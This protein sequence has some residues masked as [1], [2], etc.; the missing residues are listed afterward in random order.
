[1]SQ[2]DLTKPCI[3]ES[4]KLQDLIP[5]VAKQQEWLFLHIIMCIAVYMYSHNCIES[6]CSWLARYVLQVMHVISAFPCMLVIF[7][8]RW[9]WEHSL[10]WVS[11]SIYF[12]KNQW[13]VKHKVQKRNQKQQLSDYSYLST[14]YATKNF[15]VKV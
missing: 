6:M 12:Y 11:V 14:V 7:Q 3:I 4:M 1:M 15:D 8:L 2:T 5:R 10:N 13:Y 9:V